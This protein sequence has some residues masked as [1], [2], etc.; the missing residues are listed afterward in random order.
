MAAL[1]FA[2]IFGFIHGLLLSSYAIAH[3]VSAEAVS[4]VGFAFGVLLAFVLFSLIYFLISTILFQLFRFKHRDWILAV[5][6]LCLGA[7]LILLLQS[8]WI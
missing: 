3:S 8:G 6:S 7:S 1:F 5:E 4:L 2:G